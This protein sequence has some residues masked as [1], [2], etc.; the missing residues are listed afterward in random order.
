MGQVAWSPVIKTARLYVALY[1]GMKKRRE[2]CRVLLQTIARLCKKLGNYSA[3][4]LSL[5]EIKRKLCQ[6]RRHWH[7]LKQDADSRRAQFLEDLAAARAAEKKTTSAIKLK[8]LLAREKQ[9][10]I[11]R[12]L[13]HL[14][15]KPLRTTAMTLRTRHTPNPGE[16]PIVEELEMEETQATAITTEYESRLQCSQ[17]LSMMSAPLVHDFGYLGV[18]REAQA[19]LNGTYSPPAGTKPST[20]LWFQQL[21]RFQDT[22]PASLLGFS[23]E[24]HIQGWKK[25]LAVYLSRS[26]RSARTPLEDR[27]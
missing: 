12:R 20:A 17:E 18:G 27:S 2:H 4:Q 25:T 7:N 10:S 26:V 15:S 11:A 21:Q 9:R 19:V 24:E 13:Q 3:H 6:A 23:L 1:E 5:D 16:P 14:S 8:N 22:N